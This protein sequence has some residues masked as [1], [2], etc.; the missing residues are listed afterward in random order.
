MHSQGMITKN[1]DDRKLVLQKKSNY[2]LQ[3]HIQLSENN[4]LN[5]EVVRMFTIIFTRDPAAERNL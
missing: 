4:W 5:A 2:A 3:F 1:M